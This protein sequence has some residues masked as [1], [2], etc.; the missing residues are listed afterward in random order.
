MRGL[1]ESGEA[2]LTFRTK[3]TKI[4]SQLASMDKAKKIADKVTE[5]TDSGETTKYSSGMANAPEST[6]LVANQAR[7]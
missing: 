1:P 4:P 3:L 5:H 7:L 6:V 2:K